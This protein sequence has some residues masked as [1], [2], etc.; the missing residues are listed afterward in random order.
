MVKCVPDE[1]KGV[2]SPV[3]GGK[4]SREHTLYSS[5]N[6]HHFYVRWLQGLQHCLENT[7]KVEGQVCGVVTGLLA[8]KLVW[9][10]INIL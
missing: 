8:V 3:K 6:S 1:R 9:S 10:R 4:G 5:L 2:L 7:I